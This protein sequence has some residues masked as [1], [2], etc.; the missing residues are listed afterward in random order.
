MIKDRAKQIRNKV[1]SDPFSSLEKLRTTL[2]PRKGVAHGVLYP[3]AVPATVGLGVLGAASQSEAA[4]QLVIPGSALVVSESLSVPWDVDSDSTIDFTLFDSAGHSPFCLESSGALSG[5]AHS[6]F[7][8]LPITNVSIVGPANTFQH[9]SCSAL[10][11]TNCG[12]VHYDDF[13]LYPGTNGDFTG[14]L[15]FQFDN[16]G[17]TNY[18]VARFEVQG[19][20]GNVPFGTFSITRWAYEDSG[21]PISG[22]AINGAVPELSSFIIHL[23]LLATGAAGLQIR[24]KRLAEEDK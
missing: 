8:V 21:A 10:A 23:G 6:G 22:N 12:H 18:G 13:Q 20:D 16:N 4:V 2:Q 5:I 11:D 19:I 3:L 7:Q 24:R 15:G 17:T 1:G 9:I 14:N